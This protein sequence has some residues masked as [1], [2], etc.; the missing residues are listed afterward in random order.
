MIKLRK[1]IMLVRGGN[2]VKKQRICGITV[3]IAAI[4]L[5]LWAVQAPAKAASGKMV[6][7]AIDLKGGNTG[8]ATMIEGSG[9]TPLL[10]DSG[11]NN[12]DSIFEW[13][14]DNGFRNRKFNTLVTHWHDDHAGNTAEIIR[15]Y[16][17]GTV[18]L[19]NPS[20]LDEKN[21]AYY[22]YE[23]SY[24]YD[25]RSAA[26]KRGTKIVYM[27]K[28]MTISAGD[29]VSG[30]VLYINGSPAK[31]N[32]YDIQRINNESTVIM[33]T[34]GG[35]SFLAAGDIQAEAEKRVLKSGVDIKADIFKMSHH[36]YDRSNGSSFIKR[37]DPTYAYFTTNTVTPSKYTSALVRDG[38]V[39][40]GKISNVM[41]TRY[42]GTIRYTCSGGE[43]K[44]RA[45]RNYKEMYQR[46][47]N[48]STGKW[49]DVKYEFND[50]C[51]VHMDK[52]ILNID[53][54]YNRQLD[55]NGRVF[56]G[57]WKKNGS[58]YYLK[59]GG[60]Y[61]YHTFAE[62]DGKTYWFDFYGRRRK[63]GFLTAYG[64]KYYMTPSRFAGFKTIGK[65]RYY[66]MDTHYSD[67]QKHLEGMMMT[68]FR[69]I[70]GRKY[71]L[72]DNHC[73]TYKSENRG[74]LMAGFFTVNGK[75][76]YGANYKMK[77]YNS[78][79]YG[80][81]QKYWV[82]ISGYRYFFGSD[83]V[84]RTGFITYKGKTYYLDKTGKMVTGPFTVDGVEYIADKNGV[85][86]KASQVK[87]PA[88]L[89]K[90]KTPVEELP[91]NPEE[92]TDQAEPEEMPE[93]NQGTT[94]EISEET[95]PEEGS[96][97]GSTVTEYSQEEEPIE[98]DIIPPEN[99]ESGD[100]SEAAPE[101]STGEGSAISP[102][103]GPGE[104][105][106][107]GPEVE[108][109]NVPEEEI[110]SEPTEEPSEGPTEAAAASEVAESAAS[111]AENSVNP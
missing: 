36:G 16:K 11:D 93:D 1:V 3:L 96:G 29:G 13:L 43:I 25:V 50:E 68:G 58:K 5:I 91:M 9:G 59:K 18:Y 72:M 92:V 21:T 27:K 77:G 28:G 53:K 15:R 20:Y 95:E 8:E 64:R 57:S 106:E 88:S 101:E 46:L 65:N 54:Y 45:E 4:F 109:E 49:K 76:Y 44:V 86:K 24:Y 107:T 22:R 19:P 74:K 71:Y 85:V 66:F 94:A 41:S 14:D 75:V 51:P 69:T 87:D 12:N 32:W 84:M 83:G 35:S 82:T 26:K 7:T 103:D 23:K 55:A 110:V 52:K 70:S 62:K 90:T 100:G 60:I 2:M 39:R 105:G 98:P 73:K 6:I 99:E 97:S 40:M 10:V 47:I 67:Y 30:K 31:E 17:V 81:L 34:G 102:E 111:L 61:A 63:A 48:K 42:N 56:S 80:A 78:K 108:S 104:G 89:K 37:V 38:V 79:Y 33:F